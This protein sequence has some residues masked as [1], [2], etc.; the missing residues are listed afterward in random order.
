MNTNLNSKA[1]ALA[2]AVLM[3]S[4]GLAG[5]VMAAPPAVDTESTDTTQ[6]TELNAGDTQ[7]YN[8][9]ENVNFSWSADS[10]N[11]TLMVMQND[12]TLAS[13]DKDPYDTVSGTSYYNV[14]IP[15]D[16]SDYTG[17]DANAGENVTLT[18]SLVNDTAA[19]NADYNNVTIYFN[20]TE[21]QAFTRADTAET[22]ERST[23]GGLLG[24]DSEV[25]AA[26]ATEEVVVG[27][28]TSTITFQSN[29]QNLTDA[30][31]ETYDSA[32]DDAPV[33]NGYVMM[34]DTP[35]VVFSEDAEIPDWVGSQRYAT[36]DNDGTVTIYN[37]DE[38]AE[39]E[40]VDLEVVGNEAAGFSK[41]LSTLSDYD[42]VSIFQTVSLADGP[43]ING[44]PDF[45]EAT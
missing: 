37:A 1:V 3:V 10:E 11:S 39:D 45:E 16:A 7:T 2:V 35:V 17:L 13:Y 24:N 12:T 19:S 14:T 40:T 25:D 27:S 29:Q 18:F 41:S 34:D 22:G 9:S 32:G 43:D 8:E 5:V 6:T 42:D 20:N 28:N 36:V 23:F 31:G 4:G 33:W 26:R 44:N 15:D 38:V 30:L 21:G